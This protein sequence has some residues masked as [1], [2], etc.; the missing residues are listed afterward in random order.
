MTT[1]FKSGESLHL[2]MTINL[3]CKNHRRIFVLILGD[4]INTSVLNTFISITY[5]NLIPLVLFISLYVG[6]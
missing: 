2:R 4:P 5:L 3:L 6:T 1:K